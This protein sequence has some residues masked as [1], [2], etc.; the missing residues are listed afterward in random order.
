[1]S[2]TH[3]L[4]SHKTTIFTENGTIHVQYHDTR[5]VSFNEETVTFRTGGWQTVTTK[6]RMNQ[7]SNQFGLGWG[8]SQK[9]Y[10]WYVSYYAGNGAHI[11][12]Q[13][14]N[15]DVITLPRIPEITP[16]LKQQIAD[17]KCNYANQL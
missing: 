4:G 11:L 14:F 6:L 3:K 1:M 5:V 13:K 9:N 2:Q 15:G 16:E 8:V 10:Q 17:A 7:A 12:R